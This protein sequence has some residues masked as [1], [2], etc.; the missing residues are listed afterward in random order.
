MS[1]SPTSGPCLLG[2]QEGA[3]SS[4]VP[5]QESLGEGELVPPP[6]DGPSLSLEAKARPENAGALEAVVIRGYRLEGLSAALV[7]R[8]LDLVAAGVD[9]PVLGDAG[10]E[11]GPR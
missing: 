9:E 10:A 11:V 8:E 4:P 3:G 6:T 2:E 5:G 7:D 1:V